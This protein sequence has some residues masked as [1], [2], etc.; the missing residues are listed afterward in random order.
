VF[1][2]CR[3]K[4]SVLKDCLALLSRRNFAIQWIKTNKMK[5]M[6]LR[7]FD[8]QRTDLQRTHPKKTAWLKIGCMLMLLMSS[9]QMMAAVSAEKV[10]ADME[11]QNRLKLIGTWRCSSEIAEYQIKTHTQDQYRADGTYAS[12]SVTQIQRGAAVQ[13]SSI[14]VTA[15]WA[16]NGSTVRLSEIQLQA[17]QSDDPGYAAR[18]KEVFQQF[19]WTENKLLSLSSSSLA[20]FPVAPMASEMPI[21]CEK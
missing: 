5:I 9:P 8:L 17:V 7:I 15:Q 20:F 18:L 16:L 1:D 12:A 11:Q 10:F 13:Q 14:Q 19:D 2:I 21:H 4:I 3:I 6:D